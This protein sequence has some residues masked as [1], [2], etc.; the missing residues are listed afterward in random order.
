[1]RKMKKLFACALALLGGITAQAQTDVTS[2]YLTNADFSQS[3]ALADHL[4]GYDKDG[5]P[6]N[7]QT[8]DGWK[9]LVTATNTSGVS[10]GGYAGGVFAYGSENQ[11]KG[12]NVAAPA[13]DPDGN[14]GNCLGFF[15]VWGAGGYYYQDVTLPAGEYTINI[16]VYNQSGTSA[17]TTYFGF[18]PTSGTAQT[19]ATPTTTGAWTTLT[20]TF[21]LTS[22]TTG[23]I[24]IGYKSNGSGSGANPMLFI[25]KVQIL[26]TAAVVKD[27]LS[28]AIT[29]ASN[30]N[31]VLNDETLATAITTAQGVYDNDNATQDDVNAAAATLNAATEIAMSGKDVTNIFLTNADMSST[32]GWTANCSEGFKDFG[33]GL[34]GTY[35]VR[36]SPA[37]VDETHLSTEY[38]F[39]FECRWQ[40][41]FASYNQTTTALPAGVYKITYDVENVNA[42]TTNA[43]YNN[44]FYA[45]VGDSKY[46][47]SSTEWMN[48]GK[49]SWTTHTISA[50]VQEAAP[51]TI[52]LGYGTGSNNFPADNTP[53]LYVS[54]LKM[55]YQSFLAGAKEAYDN[56][57]AA[58]ETAKT[59]NAIVTGDELTAL[60]AEL[61]KAEPTTVDGYNEAAAAITTATTTLTNA[62]ASYNAL[63][64]INATIAATGTLQY[65]DADKKPA[66]DVTATSADDAAAK[67]AAQTTALRAYY[68]SNALAE[69]VKG[70]VDY[71]NAI[72]NANN[73]TNNDGWDWT[74]SKNNPASNE[75]WTD[76][77]GINTH[78]YFDG[79]NWGANAWTTT[80]SQTISIPAGKYILTA[81]ARAAQNVTFTM[82]V[83]EASVDLPHV[84][85]VGNVFNRGWGDATLYFENEGNEVTILVTASSETLHEWFSIADFRLVQLE[86]NS[87]AYAGETEYTAL[88]NAINTAEAK[89]LGFNKNEYAPYNNVA[90]IQALAAAKAV[91][92]TAELTNLKTTVSDLTE[93]LNDA[94]W[95]ANETDVD[96]IY[97]GLFATVTEG[98]NYPNGW[99]RTNN[100]GEMK[101]GVEGDYATAYYNQPGSLV[102]GSTGGY[103]MPLDENTVY[104]LTFAY[105]SHENNSNNG[106]TVSVLNS[107]SEGLAATSFGG[108]GSISEWKEVTKYFTTGAA[109]NYVLTLANGGNTWMTGVSLTKAVATDLTISENEKFVPAEQYANVTFERTLVAG[110]NGIVLPIDM[111]VAEVKSKFNATEVKDFESITYDEANGVT[112]NFTNATEVVAGKPVLIKVTE[113]GESYNLGTVITPASTELQ[114]VKKEAENDASISYTLKGTFAVQDL[115]DVDFALIQ[116]TN[117][118][119]HKAN[120]YTTSAK[121]FRAYF[122]NTSVNAEAG[123]RIAFNFG[124]GE[125]TGISD[126]TRTNNAETTKGIFDLQ[127][128]KVQD[129][130]RKGIYVVGGRKVVVK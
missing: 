44:L 9:Y 40:T 34:I 41:N 6:C 75:P 36:F 11:L 45:Q 3:T 78:S 66:S 128:R 94:A 55:E 25:D 120:A 64:N 91:D 60:D 49:S 129:M 118:Y 48:K 80:M 70:A 87:D 37:T 90:A 58:A 122:E 27:V 4:R 29:A 10:V 98:A 106:M 52:S 74:G 77:N 43:T 117:L 79:G 101:S 109:G 53:A 61:A 115:S 68:E 97:N 59:N 99:A 86:L 84:S 124:D 112:L 107:N 42:A 104:K 105:R 26:Y 39:G 28:T 114:K 16:P 96:A 62:A 127:G 93:T 121:A 108:N 89:T 57:V 56:A 126:A 100:W 110:W 123:A 69:G 72:T 50:T 81:K 88:N 21:T 113:G 111:T 31:A 15:A 95:T 119:Y 65:A 13:T 7:F 130:N 12:N 17:T 14:T 82:A 103:I 85:S 83:G 8:V 67:A 102:Y 71:T 30:A 24:R 35:N 23:Q 22:E 1:M 125:T 33:N 116:G 20:K 18:H 92:Q 51:I 38:C 73:P 46:T 54:H 19:M 32:E 63:A 2:T 76:A 47:D 5:T